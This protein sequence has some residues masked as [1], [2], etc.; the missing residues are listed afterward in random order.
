VAGVEPALAGS[1]P[2]T[3][4]H[5]HPSSAAHRMVHFGGRSGSRRVRAVWG[6]RQELHGTVT[7]SGGRPG[8]RW[9]VI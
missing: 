1:T 8:D 3:R 7:F 4:R 9:I 6:H 5:S 2:A